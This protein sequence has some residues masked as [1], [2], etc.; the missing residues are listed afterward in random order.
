[1]HGPIWLDDL[2]VGFGTPNMVRMIDQATPTKEYLVYICD[3]KI[4]LFVLSRTCVGDPFGSV[5]V[6][7]IIKGKFYL[8][9]AIPLF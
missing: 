3:A 1:M 7:K 5:D 8:F 9:I 6:C 2:L 4:L